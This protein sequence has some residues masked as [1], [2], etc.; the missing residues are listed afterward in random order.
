M[1]RIWAYS[2]SVQELRPVG[3][4]GRVRCPIITTDAGDSP[5]QRELFPLNSGKR[6]S[7]FQADSE[8][9]NRA[10]G[11]SLGSLTARENSPPP[12][13]HSLNDAKNAHLRL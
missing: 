12:P 10:I 5:G 1:S 7:V 2:C 9:N 8:E 11:Y 13:V 6:Q 3:S 4:T